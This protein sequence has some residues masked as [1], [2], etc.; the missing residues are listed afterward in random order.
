MKTLLTEEH[1]VELGD[2]L[3]LSLDDDN[4]SLVELGAD[5]AKTDLKTSSE[6]LEPLLSEGLT[7]DTVGDEGGSGSG[8]SSEDFGDVSFDL[9]DSDLDLDLNEVELDV[10]VE[11]GDLDEPQNTLDETDLS[12]D[13]ELD[14]DATLISD[15]EENKSQ[16]PTA[17]DLS[18][19]SLAVEDAL[20]EA[21][22]AA[23]GD[24]LE[25]GEGLVLKQQKPP[26]MIWEATLILTVT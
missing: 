6:D 26:L 5:D 3:E 18:D 25:L 12:G 22:E 14:N 15:V 10:D 11:L 7:V 17:Y 16:K 8:E 2:E 19:V 1:S 24:D 21:K 20:N 4:D 13:L 23:L 9:D